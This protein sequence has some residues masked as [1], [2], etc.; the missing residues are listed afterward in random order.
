V[1]FYSN[2][3]PIGAY[4]HH[5]NENSTSKIHIRPLSELRT[6]AK[7]FSGARRGRK[8]YCDFPPLGL[9]IRRFDGLAALAALSPVRKVE[10]VA[11]RAVPVAVAPGVR[12]VV[13]GAA[14]VGVHGLGGAATKARFA[15]GLRHHTACKQPAEATKVNHASY[16]CKEKVRESECARQAQHRANA[17]NCGCRSCSS[18]R[19]A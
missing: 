2:Y 19:H 4:K 15:L 1:H 6:A 10:V 11:G 3:D 12:T 5:I 9:K 13:V 17:R 8:S 7:S 14:S 16:T 18:S